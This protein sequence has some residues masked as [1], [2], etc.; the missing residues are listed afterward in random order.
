MR[1]MIND[2]I[3]EQVNGGG[4]FT[5]YKTVFEHVWGLL[6]STPEALAVRQLQKNDYK[7]LNRSKRSN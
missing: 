1:T 5:D 7:E 2:K 3:M 4:F 6:C